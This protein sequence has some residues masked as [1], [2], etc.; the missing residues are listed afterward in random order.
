[1]PWLTHTLI[2]FFLCELKS[3]HWMV[4]SAVEKSP[5]KNVGLMMML[6]IWKN[7][8]EMLHWQEFFVCT[9]LLHFCLFFCWCPVFFSVVEYSLQAD[10]HAGRPSVNGSV[11]FQLHIWEILFFGSF[12]S[13][14]LWL[15]FLDCRHSFVNLF[16][17]FFVVT[18]FWFFFSPLFASGSI[19]HDAILQSRSARSWV[20]C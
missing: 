15:L 20:C 19:M 11:Q 10:R 9:K 3:C 12:W 17:H 14:L 16:P 13:S 1:M 18:C 6:K 5:Q 4:R 2:Y 7:S 8:L